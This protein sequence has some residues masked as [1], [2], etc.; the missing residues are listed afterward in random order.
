MKCVGWGGGECNNEGTQSHES[1]MMCDDC[2]RAAEY[3]ATCPECGHS[4]LVN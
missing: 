1:G 2:A 4:F 3:S